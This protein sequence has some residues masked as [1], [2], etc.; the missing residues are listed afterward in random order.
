MQF[1][2]SS[3][4]LFKNFAGIAKGLLIQPGRDVRLRSPGG[5]LQA[6]ATIV[7]SFPVEVAIYDTTNFLGV[8]A[9]FR[10]PDFE[11]MEN[12]VRIVDLDGIAEV[13]YQYAPA[14]L[15]DTKPRRIPP[16]TGPII[17]FDLPDE[18]WMSLQRAA[19]LLNCK[20]IR[21]LSCGETVRVTTFEHKDPN[22]SEFSVSVAARAN[23]LRC[24]TVIGVNNLQLLK[25]A[26]HCIV[27]PKYTV[28]ENTSGY[29]LKYYLACEPSSTFD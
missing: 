16:L 29:D 28:F 13:R 24:S 25:G 21:I 22:R 9:I 7:E 5:A 11:F 2:S 3:V 10:R 1:S 18:T 4:S 23:G 26:Y 27:T 19:S 14:S 17:E 8:A 20:E 6:E 12:H 15:I